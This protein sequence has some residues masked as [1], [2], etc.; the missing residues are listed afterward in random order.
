MKTNA[1]TLLDNR[2][3]TISEGSEIKLRTSGRILDNR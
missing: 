2:N 3:T 1:D